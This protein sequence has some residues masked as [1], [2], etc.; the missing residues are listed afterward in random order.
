MLR[1]PQEDEQSSYGEATIACCLL[2]SVSSFSQITAFSWKMV[3][4]ISLFLL[5]SQDPRH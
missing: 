2:I 5:G 3:E 1:H 4:T